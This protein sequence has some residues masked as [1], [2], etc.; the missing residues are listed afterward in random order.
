MLGEAREG[1]LA[2]LENRTSNLPP[3]DQRRR[4]FK[5]GHKD[6]D[7]NALLGSVPLPSARFS[8]QEFQVAV[9]SM[10][11][12]GLTCLI[13]FT[14]RTFK[15]RALT[16]RPKSASASKATAVKIFQV[17]QVGGLQQTTIPPWA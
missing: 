5:K 10:F 17:R 1:C 9:Q 12:V 3:D 16:V 11:G 8:A 15:F 4:P 13:P 14:D 2:A 6:R 7:F